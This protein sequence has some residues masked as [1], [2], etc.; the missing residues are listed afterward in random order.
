MKHINDA[1]EAGVACARPIQTRVEDFSVVGSSRLQLLDGR[2]V[3][4]LLGMEP[5]KKLI[6]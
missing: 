5:E 1:P 2:D 6:N 3:I 4:P